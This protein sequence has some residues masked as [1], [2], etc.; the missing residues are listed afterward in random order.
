MTIIPSRLGKPAASTSALTESSASSTSL[1]LPPQL[2]LPWFRPSLLPQRLV[3]VP[4]NSCTIWNS[5]TCSPILS[6]AAYFAA[7]LSSS[8]PPFLPSP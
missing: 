2:F 1:S 6:K 8:T 5:T 7:P 4:K 3:V